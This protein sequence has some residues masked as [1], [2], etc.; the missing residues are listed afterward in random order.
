LVSSN[1]VI[2]HYKTTFADCSIRYG[3]FKKQLAEDMSAFIFPIKQQ[4]DEIR[5]NDEMLGKIAKMGAEK[6]RESASKTIASA[7][8]MIGFTK[9][10]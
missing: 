10:Y 7:R 8:E 9:F 1:D 4:I 3:D 6:A 5:G 2:S